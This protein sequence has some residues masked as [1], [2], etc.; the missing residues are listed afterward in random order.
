MRSPRALASLDVPC[1][2]RQR[3]ACSPWR[4]SIERRRGYIRTFDLQWLLTTYRR[5]AANG[6]RRL[7]WIITVLTGDCYRRLLGQLQWLPRA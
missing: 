5:Q 4:G 7:V 1:G 2:A 6:D 3:R